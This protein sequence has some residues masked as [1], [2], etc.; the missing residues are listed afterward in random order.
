MQAR[1]S[2]S[3]ATVTSSPTTTS[4]PGGQQPQPVQDDVVFNDGKEVPAN[5]VGRDPRPT[6]PCSR[7][8]RRQSQRAQLGDSDKVR[9]A[10]RCWQRVP[11]GAAQHGDHASSARCTAGP[12]VREGS[13][14][15]TVI[16]AI[17]TD[18]SINHGNSGGR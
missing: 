8:T 18:A 17:Q 6:W 14:T 10:T 3:T 15:D 4:S 1:A 7:S 13:D 11:A 9:V 2:S 12:I 16:D 5:L